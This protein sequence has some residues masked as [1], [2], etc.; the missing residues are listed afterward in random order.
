MELLDSDALCAERSNDIADVVRNADH[1]G[2]PVRGAD[3]R[4][5]EVVSVSSGNDPF[6]FE[7]RLDLQTIR[8][9]LVDQPL[10][11]QPIAALVRL[12]V[13]PVTITGRPSPT[14]LR[15]QRDYSP[16]GQG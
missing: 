9:S 10:Q 3:C 16:Q 8:S 15:S 1:A 13:L 14:R 7:R 6:D 12:A 2:H 5:H 11:Q 4:G